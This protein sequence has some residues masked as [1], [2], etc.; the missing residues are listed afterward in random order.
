[1]SPPPRR[2]ALPLPLPLPFYTLLPGIQKCSPDCSVTDSLM[3]VPERRSGRGWPQWT[4]TGG[5]L[6]L[7][8][9]LFACRANRA[10]SFFF[11]HSE[12]PGSNHQPF[13]PP[14]LLLNG[15]LRD[16]W[17][18]AGG[19]A[20]LCATFREEALKRIPGA[21]WHSGEK[22]SAGG[23]GQGAWGLGPGAPPPTPCQTAP[24]LPRS[25]S[26]PCTSEGTD[27]S[28]AP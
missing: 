25:Q 1:M 11:P 13:V 28:G 26:P 10:A 12:T 15:H 18:G 6:A 27:R 23:L 21:L 16:L 5:R 2:L 17:G 3:T 4:V 7:I 9:P 22:S 19:G 24:P 20:G 14:R 8:G